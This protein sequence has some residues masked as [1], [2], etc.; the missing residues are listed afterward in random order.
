[1]IMDCR[2]VLSY[3]FN[4]IIYEACCKSQVS[5]T[6]T[7]S[8]Q[9]WPIF[10][11]LAPVSL[12]EGPMLLSC[13]L[14]KQ[15]INSQ[16]VLLKSPHPMLYLNPSLDCWRVD[17]MS[18]GPPQADAADAASEM[19]SHMVPATSLLQLSARGPSAQR[20]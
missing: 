14:F 10:V 15:P 4:V 2:I 9:C 17:S 5:I 18:Y 12:G 3:A 19:L 1:M 13:F 6:R 11:A 8:D 20:R 16:F 7:V